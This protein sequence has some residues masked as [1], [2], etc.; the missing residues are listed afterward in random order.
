M[1]LQVASLIPGLEGELVLYKDTRFHGDHYKCVPI[2]RLPL[3]VAQLATIRK[4]N[5]KVNKN[6]VQEENEGG[7]CCFRYVTNTVAKHD[8]TL[9]PKDSSLLLSNPATLLKKHIPPY[10]ELRLKARAAVLV[11]KYKNIEPQ[12][13]S[14][15]DEMFNIHY[16]I[17]CK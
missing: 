16:N 13:P 7:Y 1:Y 14:F 17:E 11:R 10:W 6:G 12:L 9:E 15:D 2:D 5:V 8:S 3:Q 4:I